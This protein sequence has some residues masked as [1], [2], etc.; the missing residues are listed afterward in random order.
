LRTQQ[1]ASI[2]RY[3]ECFTQLLLDVGEVMQ[4]RD[5]KWNGRAQGAMGVVTFKFYE[6]TGFKIQNQSKFP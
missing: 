4:A 3:R 6:E 5:L 2:E 1:A